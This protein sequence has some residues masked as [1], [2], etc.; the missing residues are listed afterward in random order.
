MVASTSREAYNTIS[1][2]LG[3][4]QQMVMDFLE[5]NHHEHGWTNSEIADFL[6]LP[7]N[8]ITPR[9]HELRKLGLVRQWSV[10]VCSITGFKAKSWVA[11]SR[12]A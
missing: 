7:I 6:L 1:C 5:K 2:E 4:R 10:R 11:S 9:I 3:K 12:I 8:S